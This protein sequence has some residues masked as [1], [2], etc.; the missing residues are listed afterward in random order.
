MSAP[1]PTLHSSAEA[2]ITRDRFDAVA[3][4]LNGVITNTAIL[5]ETAWKQLF[6]EFL[7]RRVAMG[8]GAFAPF[9]SDDYREH[10]DGRPRNDGMR[11]FLAA[12]N[13][14]LPEGDASDGPERATIS[15]LGHRKNDLFL[16]AVEHQGVEVYPDAVALIR[17]LRESG[18]MTGVVSASKNCEA[19]LRAARLADLHGNV[20]GNAQRHSANERARRA[21]HTRVGAS[22]RRMAQEPRRQSRGADRHGPAG[23]RSPRQGSQCHR[24]KYQLSSARLAQQGKITLVAQKKT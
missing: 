9:A 8:A 16:Q 6:D 24:R 7:S 18:L 19:V 11:A 14:R 23:C 10:V 22:L 12:R 17:R 4:D 21:C 1:D 3:F 5:H 2:L 20:L 13:V 15:G